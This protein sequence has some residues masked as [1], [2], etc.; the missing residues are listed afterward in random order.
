MNDSISKTEMNGCDIE[1]IDE[2][3]TSHTTVPSS[4][5]VRLG[6]IKMSDYGALES[7]NL[8]LLDPH[9]DLVEVDSE[10]LSLEQL[11]VFLGNRQVIGLYNGITIP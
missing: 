8:F 9:Q 11:L 3:E 5:K 4:K 10:F 6:C 1:Q 2:S 7:S